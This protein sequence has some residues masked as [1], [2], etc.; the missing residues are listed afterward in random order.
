M[1]Y[2]YISCYVIL[3]YIILKLSGITLYYVMLKLYVIYDV[4]LTYNLLDFILLNYTIL[5]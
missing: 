4:L 1:L 3:H 2:I 5:F